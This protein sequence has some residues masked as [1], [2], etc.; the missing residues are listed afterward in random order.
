MKSEAIIEFLHQHEPR[1]VW[2]MD[3]DTLRAIRQLKDF[4][5]VYLWSPEPN[6]IDM[7]GKM[8][9][10]P[11]SIS[12]DKCFQLRYL[13]SDG[14]SH[15]THMDIGEVNTTPGREIKEGEQPKKP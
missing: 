14:H 4:Q 9:G 10:I 13:F 2:E 11:I 8:L 12:K 5:G 15:I 3:K 1:R 7:P 6:Y